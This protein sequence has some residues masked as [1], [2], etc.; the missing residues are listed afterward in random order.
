MNN[1]ARVILWG[2]DIGAVTWVPDR[3]VGVFQYTPEFANSGIEVAP[4]MMPLTDM[5]YEFPSLSRETFKGLPGMLADSLP[6]KF[7]TKL[8][9]A[10]LASQGRKP[11]S[12]TPIEQLFYTGIRGMG[13]LEFHPPITDAQKSST[14]E[15]ND[16]VALSNRVLDD[17]IALEDK[18]SGVKDKQAIKDLMR[19]STS[20]GGAR[21]KAV[22]SW[23]PNTGEFRSEQTSDSQGFSPWLVK[24]DGVSGNKDHE[25]ADPLGFGRI[26]Y[27][28]YLMACDA[29]IKMQ[30]CRLHEEGGRAHFMTRRFDRTPNGDKVHM[31]SLG[32]LMHYD[33]NNAGAYGYE[34]VIRT[35]KRLDLSV[36]DVEQQVLRTFFNVLARNQDD[37]V[38]NIAFLMDRKGV[39]YL[40]PAF[41]IVYSYNPSGEWTDQHQM[42]LGGKRHGFELEDLLAFAGVGGLKKARAKL[43]LGK[44]STAVSNWRYFATQ[45]G[46]S[47]VDVNRIEK[48]HRRQLF[49]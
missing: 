37:H 36:D 24:F 3:R 41:D 44:V 46:M 25:L 8:I 48:A 14:V 39:W 16:L 1:T 23:N 34:Q 33:F 32:A 6:D 9:E 29:G 13:A 2:S 45:A 31:Q 4:E 10:W 5:P 22:I 11:S 30:K 12:F 18:L 7:G 27:A 15:I 40:S 47:L 28:Y 17:Q 21:A 20:A 43:L 42:S 38:K 35:I 49:V 19:V 26:E